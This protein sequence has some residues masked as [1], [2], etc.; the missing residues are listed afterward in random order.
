MAGAEYRL[1][2]AHHFL[3]NQYFLMFQARGEN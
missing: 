3:P 1:E 2:S